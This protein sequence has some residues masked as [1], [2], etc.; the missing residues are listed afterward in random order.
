MA[1][2]TA[3]TSAP[4]ESEVMTAVDAGSLVIADIAREDAWLSMP[5]TEAPALADCR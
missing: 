5:S 3:A 2:D 4:A 1:P